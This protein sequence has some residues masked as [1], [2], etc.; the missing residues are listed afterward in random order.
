[1]QQTDGITSHHAPFTAE[2]NKTGII[3]GERLLRALAEGYARPEKPGMPPRTERITFAFEIF[4]S[5]TQ[6][7]YDSLNDLKE[8]IAYW[9]RYIPEDGMTLDEAVKRLD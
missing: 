8:T 3:T 9:K 7:P 6:Y 4:I 1:M 2:T 5:N